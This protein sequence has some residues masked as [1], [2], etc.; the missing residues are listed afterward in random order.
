[1][2]DHNKTPLQIMTIKGL[3]EATV[4]FLENNDENAFEDILA[5]YSED[6]RKQL[7]EKEFDEEKMDEYFQEIITKRNEQEDINKVINSQLHKSLKVTKL[8]IV[9]FLFPH[10]AVSKFMRLLENFRVFV[11]HIKN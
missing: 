9:N 5:H 3:C 11:F 6:T 10:Y 8:I 4:R 1:M 7:L 2:D